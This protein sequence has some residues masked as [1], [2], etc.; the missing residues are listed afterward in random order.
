MLT[1]PCL[2][3]LCSLRS[4]PYLLLLF[5]LSSPVLAADYYWV[6]GNGDW[7]D[8]SHWATTSG[9]TTFHS[10][11][12]TAN[13]DVFFDGNSFT[14]A[15]QVVRLNTDII[16]CR[17]MSWVGVTNNPSLE[18]GD[19]VN[20]NIFGSLGL[21]AQMTFDFTGQVIFAA[22][23]GGNTIDFGPHNAGTNV[24]FSGAGGW[25]LTGP[26]TLDSL[27]RFSEGNL[28]TN[29]QPVT[30]A[31]FHS[32]GSGA[33]A[34]DLAGSVITITNSTYIPFQFAPQELYVVPLYIS[35]NGLSI[36]PGT[37]EIRLQGASSDIWLEGS[38][39]L[40][41]GRVVF[42]APMG[43]SRI[44]P[45]VFFRDSPA[46]NFAELE[47]RHRTLVNGSHT[48]GNLILTAGQRYEFESGQTFTLGDIQ[49]TGDCIGGI[50]M[51]ATSSGNPANFVTNNA[52]TIDF[53]TLSSLAAGGG[54]SFIANNVI[55]L[56][57]NTG[58][59]INLKPNENFFWIGGTGDWSD[60]SNWSFTSG[61]APSGCVPSLADDVFFDANSFTGSGQ[62]V[63]VDIENSNCRNMDWS[64]VTNDPSFS[65]PEENNIRI[66][67][68]LVF[69]PAM[70]HDFAGNYF[71]SSNQAGNTI[72][73]N[74]QRFNLDVTFSG[75]NGEWI[76]LDDFYA[77]NEINFQSGT[78][79]T[80][81]QRMEGNFFKSETTEPRTLALGNSYIR[82][83]PDGPFFFTEWQVDATNMTFD[84]GNSTIECS[85]RSSSGLRTYGDGTMAYNRVV[86][87][88]PYNYVNGNVF[89]QPD[90]VSIDSLSVVQYGYFN[91][92]LVIN[93]LS[94]FAGH[95]YEFDAYTGMTVTELDANGDCT[96]GPVYM[97]SWET[98][99]QAEI[100]FIQDKNLD[101]L[102]IR[103]INNIGPAQLTANNS[104][105]GGNNTGWTIQDISSRTLYW[106]G[107]N[108]DWFSEANWSATSGGPGGECPPTPID[109]VFFD[110]N[111]FVNPNAEV[112]N[113]TS[114][115]TYARN[116]TWENGISGNPRLSVNR[117][118]LYGSLAIQG[119]MIWDFNYTVVHGD[120]NHTLETGVA[121]ISD[122]V[123][124]AEG[125]YTLVDELE[126]IET[127]AMQ[128]GSLITA[129]QDIN[130]GRLTTYGDFDK[131]LDLGNSH[132]TLNRPGEVFVKTL[133]IYGSDNR[134]DIIP[135]TSLIEFTHPTG[136][137]QMYDPVTF[138]NFL[139][140]DPTGTGSIQSRNA[141][142]NQIQFNGGGELI[143]S[144]T[145]DTLL[146]APGKTYLFDA[147]QTQFINEYWQIIG[148][149][150]TPIELGSRV[151]GSLANVSMPASG[152][153]LADFIQMRDISATGGADFLA[154]RRSTNIAN[155]NVGWTFESAPQF[156]TTGFLG[157]DRA[158]CAGEPL[159]LDA[160]NFSPGETYLWQDGSTDST[161]VVDQS[162]TYS[163][164]VTFQTSCV[165]RDTVVVL[166]PQDI[167]VD[168]PDN[169][170]ICAGDEITFNA[171]V[172]LN[173]ATYTWQD[174][175]TDTTF[176]ATAAG[177]VKVIVDL[178][179]CQERDSTILEVT[180]LP[181]VDIGDD[182]T[183]CVGDDFTLLAN[184]TAESF[185]WQDGS[186]DA[187]FTDNQPGIYWMEAVNGACPVRDSVEITYLDPG[188]VDLGP[189]S[190]LCE[191]DQLVLTANINGAN[192]TWQDGSTDQSFSARSTDTYIVV[193][194]VM[195]CTTTDSIDLVFPDLPSLGLSP[196]YVECQGT[197]FNLATGVVADNYT[198]S[199]G[200]TGPSFSTLAPGP[201]SLEATFGPCT[202]TENFTL[203]FLAPPTLELGPDVTEC[204]GIPVLLDA[205]QSGTW[206]D[207]TTA[208]T[209]TVNDPGV[210]RVEVSNAACTVRDSLEVFF[211]AA[212]DFSLGDDLAGCVGDS[213]T[214]Q[215]PL[216]LGTIT[217]F[218]GDDQSLRTFNQSGTYWVE[219]EDVNGCVSRDS[220][221]LD[222][223]PLPVI[224]LGA[225]TIVCETEP[226]TLVPSVSAGI[227]RWPDG[228]TGPEFLVESPGFIVAEADDNGCT[229]TD[230]IRV[231]FRSCKRFQ[232]YL[233]TAFSPNF[234]GI[235]DTFG[236]YFDA[237]LE[238]LSFRMQ[239]F[240]RWGAQVFISEDP[241]VL[242]D[243]SFRGQGVEMGVYVYA[244]EIT[245]RDDFGEDSTIIKGD[246]T[247]LR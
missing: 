168:L 103:D 9:G 222:F 161:L 141:T 116:M 50:I 64:A 153:I 162:G 56:G 44:I 33:R 127:L 68:S 182:R 32:L 206:Q 113:F 107:D 244:I 133:N 37:S 102:F 89:S 224:E 172:G 143:E 228:S 154:G 117:V 70:T 175:S 197:T 82:L 167:N 86:M 160:Y 105:D 148:N 145:T 186:S 218:D 235:N 158:L 3:K 98:G 21:N 144:L 104:I 140:S 136:A 137:A 95:T 131:T 90:A 19:A 120:G 234:D 14:A 155:S 83:H 30:T 221:V 188:V 231:S 194:D 7:S 78:L 150:C 243:G 22:D 1:L 93:Y 46:T 139:F 177:E 151:L 72:Q 24:T 51:E 191:A 49:A 216:D 179:G 185:Q 8:I 63:T 124:E 75:A 245:Y 122:L 88:A 92:D 219:I 128:Q 108:G 246:V 184:V 187:S 69:S 210:Y 115:E 152:V 230:E 200:Q 159:T 114:R 192:Y 214:L 110:D 76:L 11:A 61:G 15:G 41:F 18:G 55:D 163:V 213:F 87:N 183:V 16:F 13:D 77:F 57:G 212:P 96:L 106:I 169:P 84:A 59:T 203:D 208:P 209:F 166:E 233:P 36:T 5:W 174:G 109:D 123:L 71:F 118:N 196:N 125:T 232:A 132:V 40:D 171:N 135:G 26:L 223:A 79:R 190:T 27:L 241:E 164:Q 97:L 170:I 138:N 129:D 142:F 240:D 67:G 47:L 99:R 112:Q 45:G 48:I 4:L 28:N 205:G 119:D 189:D 181:T 38:D 149:N 211:L 73:S 229:S 226:F 247:V 237:E 2:P 43:D 66:A 180:E 204:E 225:D 201:Y 91:G 156:E 10:Q 130:A 227:I 202:V 178:G 31:Y 173:S 199:D 23:Q 17:S 62:T 81:D 52:I 101:R 165:I 207:G 195:G 236:P 94:L 193:V 39:D 157:Q 146:C 147:G 217:W 35:S 20:L 65:G 80:N 74:G 42:T 54:G 215:V 238:V 121:R 176:T 111:S 29:D 239:V 126:V 6:G 220:S 242:W 60:P 134:L 34:L 53:V 58:W 198:W 100:E 25:S 12:P 85:A